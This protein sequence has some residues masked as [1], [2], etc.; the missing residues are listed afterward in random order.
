MK[1]TVKTK[2]YRNAP[3]LE[4]KADKSLVLNGKELECVEA[5]NLS[6]NEGEPPTLTVKLWVRLSNVPA[7]HSTEDVSGDLG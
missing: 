3:T 1:R 6:C 7:D 5:W 4:I 2:N